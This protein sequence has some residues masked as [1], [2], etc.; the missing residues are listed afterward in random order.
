MS[1]AGRA[2]PG[3][4][5]M[6]GMQPE[7]C[8]SRDGTLTWQKQTVSGGHGKQNPEVLPGWCGGQAVPTT[9]GLPP[10]RRQRARPAEL[11]GPGTARRRGNQP[12]RDQGCFQPAVSAPQLS[13]PAI[14][15]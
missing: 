8:G 15:Y 5:G 3:M 4:L 6:L 1:R 12:D 11:P 13:L 9:P 7:R 10:P 2:A 14:S